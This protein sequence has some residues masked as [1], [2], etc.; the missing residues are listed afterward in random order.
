[1][2]GGQPGGLTLESVARMESSD[3][4]DRWCKTERLTPDV[5]ALHPG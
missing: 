5:A 3:I 1:M 4:R 2:D